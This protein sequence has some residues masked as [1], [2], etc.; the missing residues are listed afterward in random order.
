MGAPFWP[1]QFRGLPL[2]WVVREDRAW[3]VGSGLWAHV[4]VLAAL[5]STGSYFIQLLLP[6]EAPHT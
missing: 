4:L 5:P 6:Q 3:Q 2:G 1:G